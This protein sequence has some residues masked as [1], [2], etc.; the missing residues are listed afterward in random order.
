M[1]GCFRYDPSAVGAAFRGDTS[2]RDGDGATGR[3]MA[4]ADSGAEIATRRDDDSARN[5]D[6]RRRT[7]GISTGANPGATASD[8]DQLVFQSQVH[9][10]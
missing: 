3:R 9:L 1:P 4:T 2:A 6:W 10:S 7:V 5:I 8:H